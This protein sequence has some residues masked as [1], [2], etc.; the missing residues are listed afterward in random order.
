MDPKSKANFWNLPNKLSLIR[1]AVSPVLILML[2]S[3]GKGLSVAAAI[4]FIITCLTDWL[5]GYLARKMDI[6]TSFGKFLDPLADKLLLMTTLIMMIPLGRI[7]AWMVALIIG[8]EM[9]VTGLRAVASAEGVVIAASFYGKVK[10]VSQVVAIVP[11]LLHYTFYGINFHSLGMVLIWIA[12]ILTVWSGVDYFM[13][14]FFSERS[15][16]VPAEPETET[17]DHSNDKDKG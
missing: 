10:M 5:D 7:P 2:L 11:L 17:K 8:R 16:P 15:A 9:A 6:V 14:F 12:L 3:P 13:K 1:I 4:V